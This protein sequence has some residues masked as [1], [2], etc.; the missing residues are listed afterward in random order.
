MNGSETA[1]AIR[2]QSPRLAAILA[3]DDPGYSRPLIEALDA[4]DLEEL[5]AF[6]A[7]LNVI[8]G[9]DQQKAGVWLS[10]LYGAMTWAYHDFVGERRP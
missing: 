8:A 6:L 1:A 5:A 2:S 9:G 4:K 7:D 3:L 10:D